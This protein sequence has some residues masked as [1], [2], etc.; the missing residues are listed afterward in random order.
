MGRRT[1]MFDVTKSTADWLVDLKQ[2]GSFEDSDLEELE[3]HLKDEIE[4]LMNKGLSEKEAF[5]VAT[6][7]LG[8]TEELP[9]E[10]AKANSRAVWRHRFLWMA[11]GLSAY[12][13]L[14]IIV[15]L[16]SDMTAL[17]A[18]SSGFRWPFAVF[19]GTHYYDIAIIVGLFMRV[20]LTSAALVIAYL[21]LSKNRF[22]IASR[23]RRARGSW[24]GAIMLCSIPVVLLTVLTILSIY[25]APL[26]T[27]SET[28]TEDYPL[29]T[30]KE[31]SGVLFSIVFLAVSVAIAFL[32]SQPRKS[33]VRL[34]QG[35]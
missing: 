7:R 6:S 11:V 12:L 14:G 8:N 15:G 4:Q 1:V 16:L 20:V 9:E 32:L 22:E 23:Y 21:V 19:G 35:R 24:A 34:S 28:G 13:V 31:V 2:T 3:S 17:I 29:L 30:S 25:M 33:R 27:V 10:Y 26:L 18:S 5:W